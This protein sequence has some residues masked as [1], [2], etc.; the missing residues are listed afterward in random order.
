MRKFLFSIILGV[1]ALS[2]IYVAIALGSG[3][4]TEAPIV[5]ILGPGSIPKVCA[6]R[7][8]LYFEQNKEVMTFISDTILASDRFTDVPTLWGRDDLDYWPLQNNDEWVEH[9]PKDVE[10]FV[11]YFE[12]LN[13]DSYFTPILFRE[14]DGQVGA[15]SSRATCGLST[16]DWAKFRL[17][18]GSVQN[19]PTA[20]IGFIY[21]PNGVP[22]FEDCKSPSLL[23]AKEVMGCEIALDEN[24]AWHSEWA[25]FETFL[26]EDADF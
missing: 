14:L 15:L 17:G 7:A 11:R 19:K 3:P 4:K 21:W 12:R 22:E 23:K 16:F 8:S 10:T 24:W 9:T 25:I 6:E 2:G 18:L 26:A 13:L 1:I 20:S 5:K